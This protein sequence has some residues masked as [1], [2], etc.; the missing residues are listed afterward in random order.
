MQG[1][2]GAPY[3]IVVRRVRDERLVDRLEEPA[4]DPSAPQT[5]AP[6]ILMGTHQRRETCAERA[7]G[8]SGVARKEEGPCT[9]DSPGLCRT[10]GRGDTA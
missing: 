1:E 3:C 10:A 4:H 5:V 2:L 8:V 6:M 9:R 7:D